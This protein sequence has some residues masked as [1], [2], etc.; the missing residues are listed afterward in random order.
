MPPPLGH[1]PPPSMIQYPPMGTVIG[2]F[3]GA[4][5]LVKNTPIPFG[6]VAMVCCD[7][8]EG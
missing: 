7:H 4:T 3:G 2:I 8:P 6:L 5:A 1:Y